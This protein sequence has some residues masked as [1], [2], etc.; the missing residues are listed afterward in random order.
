VN[1]LALIA[2]ILGILF[3]L[4]AIAQLWRRRLTLNGA[5]YLLWGLLDVI[6][7]A[8]ILMKHGSNWLLPLVYAFMC[9]IILG[10]VLI[11]LGRF[12]WTTVETI[13]T[14]AVLIAIIVWANVGPVWATV[15][16][17][18]GVAIASIPQGWDMWRKPQETTIWVWA[19]FAMVNGLSTIAGKDW[20]ITERFY[21]GVCLLATVALLLLSVRKLK[22]KRVMARS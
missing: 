3:Y 10:V 16:S 20:S 9:F 4:P 2:G 14:L 19:A 18:L 6:A 21:P 5:T 11:R 8:S 12:A 1:N 15:V 22:M 17:T 7:G 13:T